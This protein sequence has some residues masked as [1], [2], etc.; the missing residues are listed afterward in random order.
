[1]RKRTR[2]GWFRGRAG[3]LL[4]GLLAAA[5][6]LF[7]AACG[8]DDDDD[9]GNENGAGDAPELERVTLM[10]N[11]T[12]NAQHGG[13]YLAQ[14]NGWYREAGL[15]VS[16]IEPAQA[17]AEQVVAQGNADFGISI[18]E[19]VVPAR[20]QGIPIVSIAAIIQHNDS[21]FFALEEEGITRP[22][23]FEGKTYGGYGGPLELEIL[24][25]LVEC[26]GGDPSL[27]RHVE[28]GNVDYLSGM[29]QDRFDFVWVFEGWDVLRAR[30]VENIP[31][32]SVKFADYLDCIPDWY[33][34]LI[35]T[36]EKMIADRPDTVRKFLEATARGYEAAIR[37]PQAAAE[38]L[39][40]AAPELDRQLVELSTEYHASRFVDEGRQWGLQDEEVWVTF[41]R[42]LREAGLTSKE[43]DV[44]KAY[45]NAFLPS[46]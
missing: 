30:E 25:K 37:D 26:D 38:A 43:V 17:G 5:M 19:A 7:A 39:L 33:T 23:D 31:V 3:L 40:E 14:K 15:D 42:F 36:S 29:E 8:G 46:R 32:T 44:Q 13:I 4:L 11:W 28:V 18:Q 2:R 41:E 12:P 10:L 9:A 21:S 27:V 45:T 6:M 20:E 24:N 1:M 22:K 35:I 34:P 16:I